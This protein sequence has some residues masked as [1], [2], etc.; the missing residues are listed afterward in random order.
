MTRTL[1]GVKVEKD[2]KG[3]PQTVTIDLKKNPELHSILVKA[4][5]LKVA[6]IIKKN[7]PAETLEDFMKGCYTEEEAIKESI[8]L[9]KKWPK[10]K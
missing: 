7:K 3:K 9:A 2:L 5:I 4:G 8:K 1:A 10:V 6:R